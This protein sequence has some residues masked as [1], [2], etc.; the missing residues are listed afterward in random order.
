[1]KCS[2]LYGVWAYTEFYLCFIPVTV[3]TW[4]GNGI[5][6]NFDK[7]I[8]FQT[9]DGS[10]HI[11]SI[12]FTLILNLAVTILTF[13]GAFIIYLIPNNVVTY[14]NSASEMATL[15]WVLLLSSF[16]RCSFVIFITE[17]CG[18]RIWGSVIGMLG[19]AGILHSMNMAL[20]THLIH[21]LGIHTS[22]F[23]LASMGNYFIFNDIIPIYDM[24]AKERIVTSILGNPVSLTVRMLI[25]I[26]VFI[27]L[28]I[29]VR[30]RK[31]IA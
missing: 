27:V 15:L 31:E 23:P 21:A 16:C 3:S 24:D 22:N 14:V 26:A 28:T 6:N 13:I 2:L 5:V 7:N 11:S 8:P 29:V 30:K 25:Y 4:Y 20:E 18:S 19:S 9:K 1:M 10:Y 12:L 17:F